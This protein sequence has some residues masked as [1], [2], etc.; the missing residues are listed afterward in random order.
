MPLEASRY[1]VLI[2]QESWLH[3]PDKAA[4]ISEYVRVLKPVGAVAFTDIVVKSPLDPSMAARLAAEMHA[5]NIA[6]AESY[7]ALLKRNGRAVVVQDDLS[8]DWKEILVKRLEMYCSLRDTTIAKFGEAR[9]LKYD[10]AYSHF[11]GCFVVNYL[12]GVRLVAR[13]PAQHANAADRLR[14]CPTRD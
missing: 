8:G 10:K 7:A 14:P 2:G 9:F 6:S 4:L 12:G 13:K 5:S 11:V 1:D 3:I